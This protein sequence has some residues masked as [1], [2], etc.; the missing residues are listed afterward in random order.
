MLGWI[1]YIG[2]SVPDTVTVAVKAYQE[3]AKGG[4]LW[5]YIRPNKPTVDKYIAFKEKINKSVAYS[6]QGSHKAQLEFWN[7]LAD[8]S[9]TG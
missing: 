2:D 4:Q 1:K 3:L 5:T 6:F 8:G 9:T 7:W